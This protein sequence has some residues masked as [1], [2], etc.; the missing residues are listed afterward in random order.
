M[1]GI[2]F[3]NNPGLFRILTDYGFNSY[4]LRKDFPLSGFEELRYNELKKKLINT[5]DFWLI[6]LKNHKNKQ[7]NFK[8]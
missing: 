2:Y 6:Y 1:F 8:Q 4:P 5:Q 3:F 7:L